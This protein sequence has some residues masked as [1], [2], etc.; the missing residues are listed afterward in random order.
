[1]LENVVVPHVGTWIEIE[2][3]NAVRVFTPSCL[4]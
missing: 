2:K 3:G 4:T 1:M